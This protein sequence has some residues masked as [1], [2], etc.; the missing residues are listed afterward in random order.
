MKYYR[1][2]L[3][4]LIFLITLQSCS[5]NTEVVKLQNK[6]SDEN[7]FLRYNAWSESSVI[8]TN[9]Y[10]EIDTCYDI[11]IDNTGTF[12]YKFENDTLIIHN[13]STKLP[14][15]ENIKKRFKTKIVYWK[16]E[17]GNADYADFARV[18]QNLGFNFFPPNLE[19]TVQNH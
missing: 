13:Y 10:S 15:E 1:I 17:N 7:I 19:Y 3:N 5:P 8:S 2:S 12:F 11:V 4:L 6:I 14:P 16:M 9:H 18:H